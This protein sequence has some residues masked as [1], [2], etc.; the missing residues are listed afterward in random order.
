VLSISLALA[1]P[2]FLVCS[3]R[4]QDVQSDAADNL[5]PMAEQLLSLANQSRAAQG[6]GPLKWDASLA[7]AALAHCRRMVAEGTLSHRY[8]GEADLPER[9]SQAGAHF[10]LIEENVALGPEMDRVHQEW[11]NSPSHR[12]NLLNPNVDRVGIA[13]VANGDTY[14]VVADY[15]R[16]VATLTR[17]QVESAI[18][19]LIRPSGIRIRKDPTAA[20]LTCPLER[21]APRLYPQAQPAFV[22]HWQ[23]SDVSQLPPELT[24]AAAS[25]QFTEAVVGSCPVQNAEG[26]FTFYRVAVLLY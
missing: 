17:E 1:A 19:A 7:A 22:M 14:Y 24:K 4:A 16:G 20:R 26:A 5:Q 21:G 9:A 2:A 25:G 13:V 15:T 23:N 8:G 6:A 18:I 3:L 11:L 12:T 10:S